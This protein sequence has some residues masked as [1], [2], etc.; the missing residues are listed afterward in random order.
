M[1]CAAVA[2]VVQTGLSGVVHIGADK[3]YSPVIKAA[4]ES[5][6]WTQGTPLA[7]CCGIVCWELS[8]C[9]PAS[10]LWL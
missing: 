3:D 10:Q 6:G 8:R 2:V 7:T 4:L 1:I 5:E 9:R